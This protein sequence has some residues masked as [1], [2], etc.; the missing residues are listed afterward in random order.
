MDEKELGYCKFAFE[1]YKRSGEYTDTSN[2]I[3]DV[4]RP[5][6]PFNAK[7][8]R[9]LWEVAFWK[10]KE[11]VKNTGDQDKYIS[12]RYE[13]ETVIIRTKQLALNKFFEMLMEMDI[14][15]EEYI[16][17]KEEENK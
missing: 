5:Y 9:E 15:I 12:L 7:L 13:D 1:K 14:T 4:L 6:I 3:Y 2:V 8:K 17:Q 11:A 16:N 10:E